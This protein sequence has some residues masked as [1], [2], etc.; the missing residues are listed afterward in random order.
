MGVETVKMK[1]ITSFILLFTLVFMASS[2]IVLLMTDIGAKNPNLNDESVLMLS[3]L[4]TYDTT[5]GTDYS[6]SS[7]PSNYSLTGYE[8]IAPEDK[9]NAESKGII[10]VFLFI[11]DAFIIIPIF[12]HVM[13]PF[14]PMYA[15]AW[16]EA[17]LLAVAGYFFTIAIYNAWKARRV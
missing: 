8:T 7:N 9:D 2:G 11:G 10:D 3:N 1:T 14:F 4:N 5:V 16:V 15:F 6:F 13:L 12:V 17:I